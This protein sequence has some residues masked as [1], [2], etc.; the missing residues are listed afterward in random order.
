M[1]LVHINKSINHSI[2]ISDIIATV[3]FIY[4]SL[5][6]KVSQWLDDI[7][8]ANLKIYNGEYPSLDTVVA[9]INNV[10]QYF[11]RNSVNCLFVPDT[12]QATTIK[13]GGPTHEYWRSQ[14]N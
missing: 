14:R 7:H 6:T 3:N 13:F 1:P 2:Q 11:I 4:R 12:L 5:Y 10:K 8:Y 9:V